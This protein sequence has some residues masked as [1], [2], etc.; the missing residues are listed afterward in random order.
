M[1]SL[2][3]KQNRKTVHS[4]KM[5]ISTVTTLQ[6]G[7]IIGEFKENIKAPNKNLQAVLTTAQATLWFRFGF[8]N[9]CFNG[10]HPPR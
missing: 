3:Y 1:K 10:F 2:L 4:S 7:R 8:I 5:F 6:K 9:F